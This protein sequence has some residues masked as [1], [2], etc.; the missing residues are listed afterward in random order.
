MVLE[1][2]T[3]RVEKVKTVKR[4]ITFK[5]AVIP[6]LNLCFRSFRRFSIWSLSFGVCL[7]E[8]CLLWVCISGV[9]ISG[10]CNSGFYLL[11]FYLSGVGILGVGISG[12]CFSGAF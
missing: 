4:I 12:V 7:W 1:D 3:S 8:M 9:C 6:S 10:V 5:K 11:G 2:F